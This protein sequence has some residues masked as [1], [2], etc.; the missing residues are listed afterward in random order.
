MSPQ[1]LQVIE[2]ALEVFARDLKLGINPLKGESKKRML[3]LIEQAQSE[4]EE[5]SFD[6]DSMF[7]ENLA[8]ENHSFYE[9][10]CEECNKLHISKK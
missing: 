9:E 7:D 6:D 5:Q 3:E 1:T 4:V 10:N 8:C 2:V